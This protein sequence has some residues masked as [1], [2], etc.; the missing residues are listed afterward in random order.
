MLYYITDGDVMMQD[1]YMNI[2]EAAEYL[3]IVPNTL[4]NWERRGKITAHRNP[5]NRYRV[6]TRS[7]LEKM[8]EEIYGK[9]KE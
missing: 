1:E 6:Y 2:S 7:E 5:H 9:V 8:Y 3:G 4:R